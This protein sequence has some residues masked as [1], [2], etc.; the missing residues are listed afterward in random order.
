[1]RRSTVMHE[2]D[3]PPPEAVLR[4]GWKLVEPEYERVV[5]FGAWERYAYFLDLVALW[6]VLWVLETEGS[7]AVGGPDDGPNEI[8]V[9]PHPRFARAAAA[10][11]EGYGPSAVPLE[12]WWKSWVPR[13][14]DG[15]VEDALVFRL[16][17]EES[18]IVSLARLRHDLARQRIQPPGKRLDPH[19]DDDLTAARLYADGWSLDEAGAAHALALDD[20]A[21]YRFF[22]DVVSYWRVLWLLVGNGHVAAGAKGECVGLWPHPAFARAAATGA[23]AGY[24]PEAVA[25]EDWAGHWKAWVA[26]KGLD[27]EVFPSPDGSGLVRSLDELADDLPG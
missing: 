23:W 6:G 5:Q 2:T 24:E 8:A 15:G 13:L 4:D 7:L 20:G 22:V 26:E 14:E 3:S 25:L 27:L 18:V 12:E 21:R 19:A 1:M 10:N 17:E 16:P 11:W 9:W